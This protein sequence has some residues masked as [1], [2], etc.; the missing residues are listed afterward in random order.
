MAFQSCDGNGRSCDGLSCKTD[1]ARGDN[2]MAAITIPEAVQAYFPRHIEPS[3]LWV[4]FNAQA[5]SLTIY[6]TGEPV[7]SIWDDVDEYAYIGFSL[8]DESVITGIKIEHFS[9][10]LVAPGRPQPHLQQA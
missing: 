1:E 8:K 7:P 3:Q 9:R 2:F 5:D 4:N 10:W 6:F